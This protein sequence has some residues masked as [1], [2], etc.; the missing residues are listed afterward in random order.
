[1]EDY[2]VVLKN[3]R[4]VY[5]HNGL[6]TVALDGINLVIKRGEMVAIVG[7]SGSGKST[8]LNM[9]GALD[10]PTE[11]KVIIEGVDISNIDDNGRADFRNKKIGFVF[12]S[13]NLI[14]RLKVIDNVELPLILKIGDKKKRK[15]LA[16]K[17]L[18]EVGLESKANNRPTQLSGGEQQRVAI[19][20]ALV[21]E[22][23]II[24]A[25]EPTGNLDS[26]SGE[27][28]VNLLRQLTRKGKTV[29]VVTHNMEVAKQADRIIYLRDGKIEKEEKI[30]R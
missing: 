13:Y 21:A 8:L 7:P 28:V 23:S 22:P 10:K 14:N 2:V 16:L 9:V 25:D 20:R 12:Q 29:I 3:L 27:V 5:R 6:E 26:K 11:G 17:M 24:L 18:S 30:S 15:A 19:A 4:K 1:M